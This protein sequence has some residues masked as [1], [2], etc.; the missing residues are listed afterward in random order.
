MLKRFFNPK[1]A[2]LLTIGVLAESADADNPFPLHRHPEL[3]C[4]HAFIIKVMVRSESSDTGPI[5][6]LRLANEHGFIL[7]QVVEL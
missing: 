2:E 7:A 5:A 3:V 6:F 4:R 1:G